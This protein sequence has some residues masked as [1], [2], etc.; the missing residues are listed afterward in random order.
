MRKE[1]VK[2]TKRA[3]AFFKLIKAGKW[4]EVLRHLDYY[5]SDAKQWIEENN[6]DGSERWKSLPIHLV[7]EEGTLCCTYR[8]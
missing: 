7:C 6:E 1:S 8:L 3:M 4:D 5:E 2:A